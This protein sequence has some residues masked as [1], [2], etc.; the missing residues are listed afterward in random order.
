MR[1]IQ[2]VEFKSDRSVELGRIFLFR[3]G[4]RGIV[5]KVVFGILDNEWVQYE[6][7]RVEVEKFG[8]FLGDG[9]QFRIF[10]V[11]DL[12]REYWGKGWKGRLALD[13]SQ[14]YKVVCLRLG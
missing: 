4:G 8:D 5:E 9:N 3:M 14:F 10:E 13:Y 1:V 2:V 6:Y 7:F 12:N 11:Q